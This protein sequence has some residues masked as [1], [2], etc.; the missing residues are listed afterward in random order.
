MQA[1]KMGINPS[2]RYF[3]AENGIKLAD[4]VKNAETLNGATIQRPSNM[5]KIAK[6][7]RTL[8]HSHVRFGNEFNVFNE[9]LI[10]EHLLEQCHGTMY[11]GYEPVREKVFK[12]EDYLNQLGVSV[13]PC[14]NDLVAENFLK[15]EDGT[16]Y[17]I[18]WEYSGMNDP[19]WDIAALFLENN[20]TDENQDYFL[21]HYFEG[22][23]P[24]NARRKILVYQILMDYLWA[25]WTVI[26]EAQ[27]DDFGTYGK[28]RYNRAI[29]NLKKIDL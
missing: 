23:E 9:I 17:L 28:D 1:C 8:H 26:K 24:K 11:D 21:N 25:V 3:N 20:F 2:V 15:A 13:K 18:D 22:K 16:I 14:H 19:M 10:Y 4:F 7:F 6:I 27:G 5:K 12:L 29:E